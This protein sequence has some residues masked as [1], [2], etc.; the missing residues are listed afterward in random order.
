MVKLYFA[1]ELLTPGLKIKKFHFELLTR[2]EDFQ[3]FEGL[4]TSYKQEV[5]K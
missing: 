2:W 5:D 4:L 3:V 1:S